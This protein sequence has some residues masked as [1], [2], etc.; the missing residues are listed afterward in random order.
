MRAWISVCAEVDPAPQDWAPWTEAFARHGV[1]GTQELSGPARLLGHLP[2]EEEARLDS[3][4]QGLVAAGA[5]CVELGEVV[6]E[7]WQEA[8]QQAF[9]AMR[10]GRI[11][12]RPTWS[13]ERAAAGEI[14]IVIDP[15]QAFGTGDHATTRGCLTLLQDQPLA[16]LSAADIGC[17][18][19]ILSIAAHRLGAAEIFAVE[20][21]RYAAAAARE[22][23]RRNGVPV[24]VHH[25]SFFDPAPAGRTFDL[26]VSNILSAALIS[27]APEAALRLRPGG[28]W[29]VSGIVRSNWP[30]VLEAA[31]AAGFR[32]DRKLEEQEWVTA[33]LLR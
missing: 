25:G 24:A 8:W 12:V 17:G 22:N 29:I 27:L 21:E 11:L 16:G 13:S 4:V 10:F 26:I 3:L 9:T 18:T 33:R 7:D 5:I 28:A 23:M 14:E 20:V 1:E 6:E 30:D 15:G 2:P 31:E 19:G 32:L